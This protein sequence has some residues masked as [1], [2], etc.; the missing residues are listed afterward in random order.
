MRIYTRTDTR[1]CAHTQAMTHFERP[2]SDSCFLQSTVNISLDLFQLLVRWSHAVLECGS[3]LAAN[4]C[5]PYNQHS[6]HTGSEWITAKSNNKQGY[7]CFLFRRLAGYDKTDTTCRVAGYDKTDTTCRVA[8]YDKT[9][10]TCR[11]SYFAANHEE[12][13]SWFGSSFDCETRTKLQCMRVC[14]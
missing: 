14:V 1:K 6:I 9:D 7:E 4:L 8:G 11:V 12:N 13:P 10:T 3:F 5:R 2:S